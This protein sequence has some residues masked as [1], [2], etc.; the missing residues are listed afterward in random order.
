MGAHSRGKFTEDPSTQFESAIPA[1]DYA[2]KAKVFTEEP[3]SEKLG[4]DRIVKRVASK[5][6][7]RS[8][9][10]KRVSPNIVKQ[11]DQTQKV[12]MDNKYEFLLE[13]VKDLEKNSL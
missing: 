6:R 9:N 8:K 10:K 4:K 13:R 2:K 5:E 11:M 1:Q 12:S 3:L 7:D